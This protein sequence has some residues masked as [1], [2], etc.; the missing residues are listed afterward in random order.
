MR[1][2]GVLV[3]WVRCKCEG[4]IVV[5]YKL[6]CF[7]FL[8][9]FSGLKAEDFVSVTTTLSDV[10]QHMLDL[11]SSDTIL[12]GHSLESDLRSLKVTIVTDVLLCVLKFITVF[13]IYSEACIPDHLSIEATCSEACIPDHLSI[14][15]TCSE[16]CIPD[17]LS[18]EATCSETCIPDHLS[19][20]AT[21]SGPR[22]DY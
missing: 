20:E 4:L 7:I 19:I 12:I 18:I 3:E 22:D 17:H 16:A 9:R 5:K 21:C 14:E 13:N 1:C 8:Y 6:S 10:Q 2:E 15:A 11:V